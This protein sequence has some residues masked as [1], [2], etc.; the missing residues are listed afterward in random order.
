MKGQILK[1]GAPGDKIEDD[2]GNAR[3][4]KDEKGDDLCFLTAV[5]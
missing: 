5:F 4:G 1:G 2:G 3:E